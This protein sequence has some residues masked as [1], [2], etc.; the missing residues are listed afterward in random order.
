[1]S[2]MNFEHCVAAVARSLSDRICFNMGLKW[3]EMN[4]FFSLSHPVA[5]VG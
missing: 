2:S 5:A 1:M 3:T 4:V